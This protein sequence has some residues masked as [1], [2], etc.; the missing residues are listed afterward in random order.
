MQIGPL[1]CHWYGNNPQPSSALCFAFVLIWWWENFELKSKWLIWQHTNLFLT[2]WLNFKWKKNICSKLGTDYFL[3]LCESFIIQDYYQALIVQRDVPLNSDLLRNMQKDEKYFPCLK[4]HSIN[5]SW[6]DGPFCPIRAC[7]KKTQ[8][9]WL[10][11]M[12][13]TVADGHKEGT[14]KSGIH[15]VQIHIF[16]FGK[17][18]PKFE[19]PMI[20]IINF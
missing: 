16:E 1:L 4:S 5:R 17:M 2:S 15:T 8:H 11:P 19:I 13:V 18:Q 7:R 9:G 20:T 10:S 12:R 14:Q 6:F 3:M